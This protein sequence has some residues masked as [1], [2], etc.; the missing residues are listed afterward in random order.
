MTSQRAEKVF[1]EEVDGGADITDKAITNRRGGVLRGV[2]FIFGARV[3]QVSVS[4]GKS[5]CIASKRLLENKQLETNNTQIPTS[6]KMQP[7][8]ADSGSTPIVKS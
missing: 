6:E 8:P 4:H 1:K 5:T 3:L 7:S 2:F